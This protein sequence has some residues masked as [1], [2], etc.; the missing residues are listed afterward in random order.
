MFKGE[1]KIHL[2]P[3][4]YIS[5]ERKSNKSKQT[6]IVPGDGKAIKKPGVW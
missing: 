5:R 6:N 2:Y 4:S 1:T 3:G